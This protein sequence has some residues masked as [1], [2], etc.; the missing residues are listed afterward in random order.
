MLRRLLP[1][2]QMAQIVSFYSHLCYIS[3]DLGTHARWMQRENPFLKAESRQGGVRTESRPAI[4]CKH[5]SKRAAGS[6]QC[7]EPKD[8]S[9]A[10]G[11][12]GCAAGHVCSWPCSDSGQCE[13]LCWIKLQRDLH[14]LCYR[15]SRHCIW[16]SHHATGS[17]SLSS[18]TS[19]LSLGDMESRAQTAPK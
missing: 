17:P 2:S 15:V 3:Q 1:C 10:A 5:G 13:A 6:M 7:P 4:K 18:Q 16:G 19:Q 14:G 11:Q 8:V 12:L 9:S